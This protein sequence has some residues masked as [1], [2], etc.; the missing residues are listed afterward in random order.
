MLFPQ[1]EEALD[2]SLDHD[3]SDDGDEVTAADPAVAL[4]HVRYPSS[5]GLTFAVDGAAEALLRVRVQTARY[6]EDADAGSLGNVEAPSRARKK[7]GFDLPWRRI[8][9]E[10]TLTL[11]SA[12]ADAG[13]RHPLEGGLVLFSRVRPTG[14]AVSVTLALINTNRVPVG[15]LM[16]DAYAFFQASIHVD[17]PDAARS[18]FV[19][20]PAPGATLADA[21]VRSYRLLSIDMLATMRSATVVARTGACKERRGTSSR[22]ATYPPSTYASPSRTR[23]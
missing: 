10:H 22:P 21:D 1:G 8:P 5:M 14:D 11:P 7:D 4:A 2:P 18:P 15:S 3:S 12:R 16:K 23:T 9:I 19:E 17:A 13:T 20:R 6:E